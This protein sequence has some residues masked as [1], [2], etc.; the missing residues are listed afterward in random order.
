MCSIIAGSTDIP[1][2]PAQDTSG[3]RTAH[4]WVTGWH[5]VLAR[6]LRVAWMRLPEATSRR[7]HWPANCIVICHIAARRAKP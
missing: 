5:P 6:A 7:Q 1:R 3:Q 2:P 4:I